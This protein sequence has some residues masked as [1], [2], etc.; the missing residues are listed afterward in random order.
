MIHSNYSI[1]NK[2]LFSHMLLSS[3][4]RYTHIQHVIRHFF[5]HFLLYQYIKRKY[6]DF[7]H[8]P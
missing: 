4:K 1:L 6:Q 7:Y 2:H 8:V 5:W 3:F